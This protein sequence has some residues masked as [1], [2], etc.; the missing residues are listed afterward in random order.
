MK[1]SS[2]ATTLQDRKGSVFVGLVISII[3][4]ALLGAAMLSLTS[5]SAVNQVWAN[6]SSRAYYLAESG[7]RY[8]K[9]E[10]KNTDDIDGDGE[11]EDDRNQRWNNL[12]SPDP[13][14]SPVLFTFSNNMEKFELKLYPYYFVTSVS[15]SINGTSLQTEFSGEHP[16]NFTVPAAGKLKIGLKSDSDP[17]Y[18]YNGYDSVTGVF[19]NIS[20]PLLSDI[21]DN[22][23][24]YLVANT[25]SDQNLTNGGDL[26]LAD[27]SFFPERNGVFSIDG[28]ETVYAYESKTGSILHDIF[29]GNDPGRTFNVSVLTSDDIVLTPF[30]NLHSIGIVDYGSSTEIRRK[31][32]Y[33][34]PLS[35]GVAEKVEFH[36]T[37]ED[38]SKWE[39]S[40]RGLHEIQTIGGDS[41]LRVTDVTIF[42]GGFKE[43][44]IG[45]DWSATNVDLATAHRLGNRYFLDYDAQVK[46]GY[47]ATSP[48]P[49]WGYLPTTSSIPKYF[50]AGLSFRLYENLDCYGLSFLRGS[51]TLPDPWDRIDDYL[52]PKDDRLLVV[53]WQRATG[54]GEFPDW[55][56]YK[57]ID[58]T[59]LF[60][61][62]I[63]FGETQWTKQA[64]WSRTTIDSYSGIYC[65]HD[66]TA[67]DYENNIDISLT[68]QTI[69]LSGT[70][71]AS[72]TFWHHYDIQLWDDLL[73]LGDRADVEISIDDGSTWPTRLARYSGFLGGWTEETIDLTPYV[74]ESN[75]K[76]RFRLRTDAS[77]RDNGWYIDDVTVSGDDFPLNEATLLVRIKESASIAFDSGGTS[78]IVDGDVIVGAT[79]SASGT[80]NGTPIVA[81]GSWAGNDAAGTMLLKNVLGNFSDGEQLTVNGTLVSARA[82][83][84]IISRANYIRAYYGDVSGYGTPNADPFDNDKH[85][86]PRNP[87]NVNWTP[88]EVDD[89]SA[90]NDYFTLI[91][92][93]GI[94]TSIMQTDD[95]TQRSVRFIQSL[96]EPGAV[97]RS[98]EPVLFTPSSGVFNR[99]ELG[100]H[101]LGHG[102]LNVY[103]DDFALQTEIYSTGGFLPYIQE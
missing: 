21:S 91:Q 26:T 5:T 7:F 73:L 71:E 53:L 86:N 81:S 42:G 52:V 98:T 80:V 83:D 47:A 20:P 96:D 77:V 34:V 64:P 3:I 27:A 22:M 95:N 51:N 85:G 39:D 38:K 63:E 76:I 93:D 49:E 45:L 74:G 31:I 10:Y 15:H 99:P 92:W 11:K 101:T 102:S 61:D 9:T 16:A 43:S 100:L 69:N 37:F 84:P 90:D 41:A 56:A 28:D 8:A 79:S 62:N 24:V 33:H 65:W 25:S 40:A 78:P 12:H 18:T 58:A 1:I 57:D 97:I 46:I 48:A 23:N 13:P 50:A 94:N 75:V 44:L 19:S 66:S 36:D 59:P 2:L 17:P 35:A 60:S 54:I 29:D 30:L 4:F 89:W 72:L 6:S 70:S 82:R 55:L 68:T 87:A 67:G 103:F 14:S 32:V 88:D